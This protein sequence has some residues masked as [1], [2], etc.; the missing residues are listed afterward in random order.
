MQSYMEYGKQIQF[1]L[2]PIIEYAPMVE[3]LLEALHFP[4]S[5]ISA[6]WYDGEINSCG[7]RIVLENVNLIENDA[8]N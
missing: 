5:R 1:I 2:K 7:I 6:N 3:I 4:D 8:F